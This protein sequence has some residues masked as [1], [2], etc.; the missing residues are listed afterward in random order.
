M[1]T[2]ELT[3]VGE[4]RMEGGL[5]KDKNGN[6]YVDC[7]DEPKDSGVSVVYRL[8][9]KN[10]IDGEPDKMIECEVKILNPLSEHEK[11]MKAFKFDYMMLDRMRVD[12]E[13]Y[14]SAEH[15]NNSHASTIRETIEEMKRIWNK[16]PKD[17]KPNWITYEQ[18]LG[19]EKKFGIS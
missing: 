10:E 1:K 15:F 12:C 16:F 8:S 4:H 3:R 14:K 6:Y 5:Y 2:L 7:H 13:Y 19:Y 17:L 9:P 18:I 11:R